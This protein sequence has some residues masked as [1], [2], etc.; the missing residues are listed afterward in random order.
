MN[1]FEKF[2]EIYC[3]NKY[4]FKN[5]IYT[6]QNYESN[7]VRSYYNYILKQKL[8]EK[9]Y[10][11][12][13]NFNEIPIQFSK[14][15]YNRSKESKNYTKKTHNDISKRSQRNTKLRNILKLLLENAPEN[16]YSYTDVYDEIDLLNNMNE[17]QNKDY[18]FFISTQNSV[19]R[20]RNEVLSYIQNHNLLQSIFFILIWGGHKTP[21]ISDTL[22]F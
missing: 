9:I 4:N 20:T 3:D 8:I 2:C 19:S 11:S 10:S 12:F 7:S 17:F 22:I 21:S 1:H 14:V 13:K 15:F 6:P 18:E 5:E 16:N